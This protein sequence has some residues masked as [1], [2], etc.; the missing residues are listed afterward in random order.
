M[1]TGILPL[2]GLLK[3]KTKLYELKKGCPNMA[4][5]FNS[6]NTKLVLD[7]SQ[8]PTGIMIGRILQ[9]KPNNACAN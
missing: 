8:I 9:G 1:K 5:F 7:L 4:A 3:T 2:K 6:G